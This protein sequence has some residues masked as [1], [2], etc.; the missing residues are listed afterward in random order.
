MASNLL[1]F[2]HTTEE[3]ERDRSLSDLMLRDAAPLVRHVLRERLGFYVNP[4]AGAPNTP[5]AEDLYQEVITKLIQ[6]VNV[7][8]LHPDREAIR[9][10]H[11]Y[12]TRTARNTCNEYLRAKYPARARLKNRLR[13]LLERDKDFSLWRDEEDE[14][15]CGFQRWQK[16]SPS[17]ESIER[18]KQLHER[19]AV[20]KARVFAREDIQY[21]PLPRIVA[22]VLRWVNGPIALDEL[23]RI[24]GY[25]QQIRD[26]PLLSLESDITSLNEQPID[27]SVTSSARLE[28]RETL[29]QLWEEICRLPPKQRETFYLSFRDEKGEDLF[30]LLFRAHV[31][32]LPEIARDL[33]VP[34]ERLV[35][36]W[37]AMPMDNDE[38]SRELKASRPQLNKWRF[39]A[40][41]RLKMRVA[42]L[43]IRD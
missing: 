37:K 29:Q 20:F 5:D 15:L 30:S 4:L 38:L 36:L 27:Q 41:E 35:A 8:R 33:G 43:R 13:D 3:R 40:V 32:T 42:Q 21:V 1:T 14:L 23:V 16:N 9:N 6:R 28:A 2:L 34:L 7:Q 19:A 12:V 25:L 17:I 22:E 11:W 26:Y 39:R 18:L 24:V 10:F 31:V